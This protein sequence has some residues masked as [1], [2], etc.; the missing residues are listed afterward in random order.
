MTSLQTLLR[1]PPYQAYSYAYPHK[2]A[3][4]PLSP[5][6]DLAQ[7]WANE[8]RE[9]LFLYLHIPFCSMR[10]GFCNLFT[11]AQPDAAL[12]QAF[13]HQLGVQMQRMRG[14]LG[15]HQF[16]RLA[17]GGGTPTYLS[18][19]QLATVLSDLNKHLNVQAGQ[20]PS[21]I[22]V[23]P[24][25][26][27]N[28]RLAVLRDAGFARISMGVQSF[29]AQETR[30][31]ARPQQNQV[32]HR[33]IE[34]VRQHGFATLNLDLIYGIAG[35]TVAS[36][37]AS[38]ASAL[39]YQPEEIYLYPLYVRPLTGL[40]RPQMQRKSV[41]L[42]PAGDA[43]HALYQAARDHL[44]AVGYTQVSMRM[45]RAPHAPQDHGPVY[46]C[47][48]DGMVGLGCGGRSYTRQLHYA[49]EFAVA[50]GA[51]ADIVRDYCQ[52]PA[53]SFDYAHHG[54]ALD[55]DEQ[56]RRYVI[57]SLLTQPGLNLQA[58]AQRFAS[59]LWD[60]MPWLAELQ[61][62]QLATLQG[63]LLSLTDAGVARSD[64]IGPWLVSPAVNH[65]MQAYETV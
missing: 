11:L 50:R 48:D 1:Q 42:H 29:V 56:R 38:V 20:I 37:L 4:R 39:V 30:S 9:A 8:P 5:A 10:C 33:A 12:V 52:R 14:V 19:G 60:D 3:Y 45:F 55:A 54:C 40:D 64:T 61:T 58:Y 51:V 17:I 43:P 47:Q 7:L 36:F 16:A 15:T 2:T 22:E 6:V 26:V 28:E 34:Q 65:R 53:E 35:Q 24:E 25:T 13:V 27:D 31:L 62:H 32:V 49:S 57:Q 44:L 23:S 59:N 46:C 18:A 41:A 21:G 63:D